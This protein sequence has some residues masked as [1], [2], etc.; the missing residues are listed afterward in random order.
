M[1]ASS[2]SALIVRFLAVGLGVYGVTLLIRGIVVQS[3]V[4]Q[5]QNTFAAFESLSGPGSTG[6]S[7]LFGGAA[8]SFRSVMR[9][10]YWGSGASLVVSVVLYAASRKLGALIAR[11]LD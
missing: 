11:G 6:D 7:E 10:L 3:Q 5:M 1:T 9:L 8:G 4:S 2:L